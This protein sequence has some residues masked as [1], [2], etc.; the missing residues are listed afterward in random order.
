ME[1]G[2]SPENKE[3]TAETAGFQSNILT[4]KNIIFAIML[5]LVLIFI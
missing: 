5:V 3:L 4:Y 1:N 2:K